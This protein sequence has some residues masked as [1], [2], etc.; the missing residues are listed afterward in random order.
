VVGV[1]VLTSLDDNALAEIGWRGNASESVLSLAGMALR[2]GV[3][4]L[5]AS[6]LEAAE[7]RRDYGSDP[8]IVTPGI[9]ITGSDAGDQARTA[10]PAQA[11]SAGSDYLVLGRAV[12]SHPDPVSALRKVREA[13]REDC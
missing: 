10:T 13:M 6:A 9:R 3:N 1:T 12:I 8:V 5:V 7:L 11:L 2:C 4:G